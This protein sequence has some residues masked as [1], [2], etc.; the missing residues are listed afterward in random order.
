MNERFS[1]NLQGSDLFKKIIAFLVAYIVCMA[2]AVY[3]I[4]DYNMVG[5]F[6]CLLL[7]IASTLFMSFKIAEYLINSVSLGETSFA[8][9]GNFGSY[10]GLIVKGILLSSITLGIYSPWFMKNLV[11]FFT[12]NT[13]CGD[14]TISFESTGG[15][16]LK[17]ILLGMCV[18]MIVV[19]VLLTMI[20]GTSLEYGGSMEYSIIYF[21]SIILISSLYLYLVYKWY[22]N[23]KFGKESVKF[24][25]SFGETYLFFLLQYFLCTITLGIY[26]FAFEVKLIKYIVE[27][28]DLVD[29]ESGKEREMS[30]DGGIKEGFF[31]FLGQGI[32]TVITLGIYSPWAIAKIYN[33]IINNV[34][35]SDKELV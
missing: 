5:Y 16:L 29:E 12:D 4:S 27:K 18:P 8:F 7:A 33:W 34:E 10:V 11:S 14:K 32:L 31:L 30:F 17:Y 35:I 3:M 26:I 28:T 1:A 22:I 23:F 2:S 24:N 6:L 13:T 19:V 15:K 21:A 25:A 9:S 20:I